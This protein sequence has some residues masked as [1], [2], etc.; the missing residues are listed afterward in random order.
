MS[1]QQVPCLRF[2]VWHH[3]CL[4]VGTADDGAN[5]VCTRVGAEVLPLACGTEAG[6]V[7]GGAGS[8]NDECAGGLPTEGV[9]AAD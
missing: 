4:V 1:C 3:G 2:V 8:N 6:E 7:T 9:G 5:G